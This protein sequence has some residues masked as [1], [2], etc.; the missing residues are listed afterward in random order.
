MEERPDED[1]DL[2]SVAVTV[3]DGA[4]TPIATLAGFGAVPELL[5]EDDGD[6]L[7]VD[8]TGQLVRLDPATAGTT[9][10]GVDVGFAQDIQAA[11]FIGDT[12]LVDDGDVL[13]AYAAQ[14]P[15]PP[16]WEAE[17]ILG[18]HGFTDGSDLYAIWSDDQAGTTS[19]VY[20]LRVANGHEAWRLPIDPAAGLTAALEHAGGR[21]VLVTGGRLTAL[22]P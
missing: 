17:T 14:Q 1:G 2:Q 20:G 15:G 9:G 13:S 11:S 10:T 7:L 21:L 8:T 3:L 4:G 22:V 19:S 5:H 16:A 18:A 12:L 6:R